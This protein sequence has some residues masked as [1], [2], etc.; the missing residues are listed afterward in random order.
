METISIQ[1]PWAWLIV[2]G[3][4]GK[5]IENRTRWH[6]KHRGRVQ[7]HAGKHVDNDPTRFARSREYIASLGIQI[8][9]N[10]ANR[11]HSRR[12]H[13]NRRLPNRIHLRFE[14]PV[15]ITPSR[16]HSLRQPYP[17]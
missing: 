6:Y 14:G 2:S 9:G 4:A 10:A 11:G 8:P 1:Q 13:H 17:M 16:S 5:D 12:G 15:G 3:Q 7:I